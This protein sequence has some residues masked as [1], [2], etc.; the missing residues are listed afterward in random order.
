MFQ[1]DTYVVLLDIGVLSAS[2]GGSI[3]INS[4]SVLHVTRVLDT[5]W[6]LIY[7]SVIIVYSS[8]SEHGIHGSKKLSL[9]LSLSLS[10]SL[11][12]L[13]FI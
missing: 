6:N 10:L 12:E 9:T 5:I 4:S 8:A 11:S 13:N 1:D 2:L 7:R 3:M